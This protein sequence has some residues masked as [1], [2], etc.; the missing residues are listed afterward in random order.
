[1]CCKGCCSHS[2][3]KV[4]AYV[5]LGFCTVMAIVGIA[6]AVYGIIWDTDSTPRAENYGIPVLY[7]IYEKL[8]GYSSDFPRYT[9]YKL[10]LS[11]A[12]FLVR[13]SSVWFICFTNF[14]NTVI[15]LQSRRTKQVRKLASKN[16]LQMNYVRM[17]R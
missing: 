14:N 9:V 17:K 4:Q 10:T 1:M 15:R 3:S 2:I 5:L 16:R 12:G 7:N 8:E 6:L 13:F 11:W